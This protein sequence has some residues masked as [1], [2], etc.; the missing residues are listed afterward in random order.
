MIDLQNFKIWLNENKNYTDKT[1]SNIVSRFKRTSLLKEWTNSVKYVNELEKEEEFIKLSP[2]VKS[3]LKSS[4]RL[5]SEFYSNSNKIRLKDNKRLKVISLFSNIGVAEAYF[6]QIGIDVVIANEIE[7]RRAILY[8]KIYPNTHMICGDIKDTYIK[9]K[10]ITEAEKYNIDVIM[11][12]PPCQ[13]MSTAGRQLEDDERNSLILD[14]IELILKVNPRYIFIE[15]V[16]QFYNTKINYNSERILITELIS[17]ILS[18]KYIINSHV[19]N[20]EDYSVPQRRERAIMLL[21]RK[22]QEN[23]WELPKKDDKIVT[24]RDAIGFLPPVDPFVKDISSEEMEKMFPEYESRKVEALEISR[25]HSPPHHIKRQVIAMQ[26]TPTGKTAF[27]NEVFYPVKENG[28]AVRGYR[29]TYKRQ[30][31]DTPAYTVTMD[32]RKISSQNNVHPGRIED[33]HGTNEKI[34]SDARTLTLYE[35]MLIMS[36]P[37][38]WNIPANSSEAFIRRI[39]G[40]GIPPLFTKKV[41]EK[42]VK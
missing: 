42:I 31:W 4:V 3:Q 40:E 10:I 15:N 37:K 38:D 26:H 8:S 9:N 2:M 7:E 22:D 19:I 35:L 21:T 1:V 16:P 30:N 11:A 27:D 25:W 36:L 5:Y 18:D 13:G 39:I 34:Y 32:N 23:K 33:I 17:N 24:M 20:T 12:T 6:E 28:E 14:V 41:F 29:N